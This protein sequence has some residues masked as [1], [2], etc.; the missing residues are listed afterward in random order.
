M[1]S[2]A[3][4]GVGTRLRR[5]SGSAWADLAEVLNISGP[6]MS[7]EQIDVTSLASTGG[8]REFIGGFRDGGSLSFSMN[9]T[10]ASYDLLMGDFEDDDNKNYELCL[11]DAEE[12]SVE[13]EGTV[14]ELPL[15]ITPDKQITLD[16]TIKISG[17]PVVNSGTS[18]GV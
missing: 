3:V 9:F 12:T 5:W 8:Y 17:E 6:T 14:M 16:V 7:K 1:S 18:T 4:A 13:F 11:P 2:N 10:R 15:T